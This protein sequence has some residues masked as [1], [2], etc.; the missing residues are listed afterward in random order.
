[1][2]PDCIIGYISFPYK[3]NIILKTMIFQILS[4]QHLNWLM[5]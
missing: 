5:A 2:Q 3:G 4:G 1:M